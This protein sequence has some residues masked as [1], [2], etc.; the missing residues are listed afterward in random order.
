MVLSILMISPHPSTIGGVSTY[1]E[2]L[3]RNLRYCGVTPYWVGSRAGRH[4]NN[5]QKILRLMMDPLKIMRIV[6]QHRYDVVH[7][8]PSLNAKSLIRDGLITAALIMSGYRKILVFFHGWDHSVSRHIARNPFLNFWFRFVLH[9]CARVLVLS[10]AFRKELVQME[11]RQEIIRIS[12]TMV[13]T[14]TFSIAN[15][16]AGS[17][18][19]YLLFLSRFD[20][21]KGAGLLLKS[22][23][24]IAEEFPEWDLVLAGDGSEMRSIQQQIERSSHG[25]KIRVPGHVVGAEKINL[26]QECSVFVLPTTYPEGMPIALLEAMAAGKPL[27]TT[28]AGGIGPIIDDGKNGL[29]LKNV[30][31]A[32]LCTALRRMM[33]DEVLRRSCGRHNAEL[34]KRFDAAVVAAE[35]EKIYQGIT[36]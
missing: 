19:P 8:N 9:R 12:R 23:M 17:G 29:V 25:H 22:F 14:G 33:G 18:R 10:E 11:V 6:R 27:L 35:V 31:Q 13:E 2:M 36:Q 1:A 30:T 4:E 24:Q 20:P 3:K 5:I 21:P 15:D 32:N 7:I 34:A 28:E 16:N 26:L